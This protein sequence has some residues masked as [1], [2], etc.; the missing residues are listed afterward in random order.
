M[1]I[2]AAV[3]LPPDM[4]RRLAGIASELASS[5]HGLLGVREH[6][7]HLTMRFFGEIDERTVSALCSR[8]VGP[9]TRPF[10]V[11]LRG[12]GQ[13]PS[14]GPPRVLFLRVTEG[15]EGLVRLQASFR[16]A[17]DDLSPGAEDRR[18][19]PHVTLVRNKRAHL[20]E[21]DPAL[22]RFRAALD[23]NEGR[24][25]VDCI[26]LY[27]SK[28]GPGGPTYRIIHRYDFSQGGA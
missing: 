20:E 11:H 6:A 25:R 15:A 2:F 23:T 27:E 28:L 4:R 5:R 17:T 10:D 16:A 1:R 3:A 24:V 9:G 14:T 13:F 26:H 7:I 22:Q 8:G 21:S 19:T 12:G 18:Y